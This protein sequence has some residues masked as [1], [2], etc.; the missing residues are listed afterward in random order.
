MCTDEQPVGNGHTSDTFTRVSL[1]V[2]E[3]YS[4]NCAALLEHYSLK[5]TPT[6]PTLVAVTVDRR[7]RSKYVVALDI[8]PV[9]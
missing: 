1:L 7:R 2:V 8:D 5:N 4:P 3:N 6:L 9:L